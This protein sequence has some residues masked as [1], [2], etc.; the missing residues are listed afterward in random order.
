MR[1]A[2]IKSIF[3][4]EILDTLRDRRT[5]IIMI[6]VPVILYPG[7]ML[8]INDLAATQQAKME[9]KT[10]TVAVLNVPANSALISRLRAEGNIKVVTDP[11]AIQ[12]VKAGE[13]HFVLEAPKDM[14]KILSGYGSARIR[15][16]YDRS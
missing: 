15:L 4:K 10:I 6:V 9:K 8:F 7:L 11:N 1:L 2:K 3:F 14:D 13:V 12:E 16:H 5:L